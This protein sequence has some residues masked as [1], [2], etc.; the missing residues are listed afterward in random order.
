MPGGVQQQPILTS[1]EA[2]V[3]LRATNL[4]T[5]INLLTE[6]ASAHCGAVPATAAAGRTQAA[7]T[8]QP[9]A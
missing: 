1:V 7:W 6:L 9:E 3:M 8:L 2:L 4:A 5:A